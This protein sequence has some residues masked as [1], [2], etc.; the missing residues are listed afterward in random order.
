MMPLQ[1]ALYRATVPGFQG[2]IEL[3][4]DYLPSS[5]DD[6]AQPW[7]WTFHFWRVY[8][9]VDSYVDVPLSLPK[10]LQTR[11]ALIAE[12]ATPTSLEF[13]LRHATAAR[14]Q[15]ESEALNVTSLSAYRERRR[16]TDA[17]VKVTPYY[18][19]PEPGPTGPVDLSP[20][21]QEERRRK[22]Q[23]DTNRRTLNTHRITPGRRRT[24]KE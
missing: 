1:P 10:T 3:W 18:L 6:W 22:T 11:D 9:D 7:T 16:R 20:A 8:F 14:H 21:A 5:A 23:A 2:H 17:A 13:A 24:D 4:A 15:A 19:T 12:Y